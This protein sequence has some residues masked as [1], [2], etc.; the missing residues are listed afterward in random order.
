LHNRHGYM[1]H[2]VTESPN[3]K[4]LKRMKKRILIGLMSLSACL[5][6]S[7]NNCD[8]I[9]RGGVFN[10]TE[11]SR[12]IEV[13]Q[14]SKAWLLHQKYESATTAKGKKMQAI[15]ESLE[16]TAGLAYNDANFQETKSLYALEGYQFNDFG[17]MEETYVFQ[18]MADPGI[19]DAWSQCIG[20]DYSLSGSVVKIDPSTYELQISALGRSNAIKI[21]SKQFLNL[22]PIGDV[23]ETI[24]N[25]DKVK[26]PLIIQ[27]DQKLAI[28]SI[29]GQN[30]VGNA[31]AYTMYIPVIKVP[32]AVDVHRI[33]LKKVFEMSAQNVYL[34]GS[35]GGCLAY[36]EDSLVPGRLSIA[37]TKDAF[38]YE[39]KIVRWHSWGNCYGTAYNSYDRY[40]WNGAISARFSIE[41]GMLALEEGSIIL[42]SNVPD[43][44]NVLDVVLNFI[45][46]RNHIVVQ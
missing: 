16:E 12:R 29:T 13:R 17:S 27:E 45:K 43:K 5:G 3:L 36:A 21:T 14:L 44:T 34:D 24:L 20:G 9:L 10:T 23:P 25:G 2:F 6:F 46:S 8:E 32:P 37:A 28:I 22:Q 19:I 15:Y 39:F 1:E 40:V 26:I 41:N 30:K 42:N 31:V 7:Q 33:A 35:V 11:S 38:S 4:S 18:S